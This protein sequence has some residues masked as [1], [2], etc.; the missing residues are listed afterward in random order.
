M[1]NGKI[2]MES[3]EFVNGIHSEWNSKIE[4]NVNCMYQWT[5]FSRFIWCSFD[6]PF[7]WFAWDDDVRR[8]DTVNNATIIDV[9]AIAQAP[10]IIIVDCLFS[11]FDVSVGGSSDNIVSSGW[12][13]SLGHFQSHKNRQWENE[14]IIIF[15]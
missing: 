4:C 7:G 2:S 10:I 8:H 11:C 6:V 9:I 14:I 1:R 15:D 5:Y 13:Y 3:F 12:F